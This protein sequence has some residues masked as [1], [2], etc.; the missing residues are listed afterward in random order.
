MEPENITVRVL[1]EIRDEVRGVREEVA[2]VRE[3]QV[4]MREEQVRMREEL[5]NVGAR[6]TVVEG[7]VVDIAD[8]LR[9]IGKSIGVSRVAR[10]KH[11]TR[12]SNLERRV[13]A[14]ESKR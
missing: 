13:S 11:E 5:T 3:E 12:I 4:R 14:L 7:A 6:I 1:K 9:F 10:R 2:G 8:Q